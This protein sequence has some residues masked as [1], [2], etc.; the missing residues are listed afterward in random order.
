MTGKE[1]I[2]GGFDL[3]CNGTPVTPSPQSVYKTNLGALNQRDDN[4][5]RL[6]KQAAQRLTQTEAGKPT[7]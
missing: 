3:I 6:A 5:R 4:L 7:K 1:D 2:V